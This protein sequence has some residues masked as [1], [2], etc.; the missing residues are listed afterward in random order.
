MSGSRVPD[1][2]QA[3]PEPRNRDN[4]YVAFESLTER[5]LIVGSAEDDAAFIAKLRSDLAG[6]PGD[7]LPPIPL[8]SHVWALS[9]DAE[10]VHVEVCCTVPLQPGANAEIA[11]SAKKLALSSS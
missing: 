8:L 1:V 11:A 5:H 3:N 9:D 4:G 2:E 10:P 7:V 6:I